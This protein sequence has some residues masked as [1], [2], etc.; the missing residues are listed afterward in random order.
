MLLPTFGI[1]DLHNIITIP[2]E[3]RTNA[4]EI[5]SFGSKSW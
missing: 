4:G 3:E 5:V 2:I 1:K